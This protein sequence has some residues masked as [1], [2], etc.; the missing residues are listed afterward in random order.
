[1]SAI[2]IGKGVDPYQLVMKPHCNFICMEDLVRNLVAGVVQQIPQSHGDLRSIDTDVFV[3][4]AKAAR[5]PQISLGADVFRYQSG[6]FIRIKR[7]GTRQ[8]KKFIFDNSPQI[9]A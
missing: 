1:M 9:A 5:P 7:G 4:V 8:I 2:A 6:S 3:A